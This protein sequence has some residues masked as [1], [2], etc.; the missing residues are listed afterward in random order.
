MTTENVRLEISNS[1]GSDFVNRLYSVT[2]SLGEHHVTWKLPERLLTRPEI[3][4]A[5]QEEIVNELRWYI[6]RIVPIKN[7]FRAAS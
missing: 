6:E 4:P 2:A 7:R 5:V 1:G 3:W